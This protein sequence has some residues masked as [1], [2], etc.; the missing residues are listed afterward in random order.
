LFLTPAK[1]SSGYKYSQ[2]RNKGVAALI[3]GVPKEIKNNEYRVAIVPSGVRA[4]IENGH[5]V[6][7]QTSAGE[8]AGI[9]DTEYVSAGAEIVSSANMIFSEAEMIVKVKEPLPREYKLLRPGQ[10]LFTYLHLAPAPQLTK[11]LLEQGIVGIAY[12]TVQLDNGSLPLLTPMSEIAGKLSVQIAARYLEKE[13]GGSGVLL[14]GIPGVKPG[15]VVIIGGGT[16]G[17]NAAKI[18]LGMGAH[19][20]LLDISLEKLRYLDDVLGGRITLLASNMDN[21][22]QATKKA[23]VVIGGVL[24]PGAKAKKLVTRKMIS[25]MRKG[26]VMVDVAIDQ[27]G[28]FETS[29][30]TSFDNPTFLVD[31]V[32]QYCVANMPGCVARTSTFALTNATLPYVLKLS[33]LGYDKALK[34]DITLRKGL[35]VYKGKLTNKPVAD[36]VGINYIPYES[37]I[38]A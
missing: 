19:V 5:H 30:A 35:N 3:V 10:L 23:D 7:V 27:G 26:S 8:G 14:G 21:I 25:E 4:L 38:A 22:E 36:A 31:G 12:E 24:I 28:C 20:T 9:P 18:A 16:V 1:S 37:A 6:L 33:N 15:N 32:I 34:D 13:N 2:T 11:V 17:Q 29:V